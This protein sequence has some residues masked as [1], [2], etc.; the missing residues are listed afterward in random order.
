MCQS[1]IVAQQVKNPISIHED[2]GLIPGL[3][4]VLRIWLCHVLWY[5]SQTWLKSGI[6][7]SVPVCAIG[8]QLHL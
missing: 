8:Q 7:V 1:S 5:T 6:A 3:L 4:S 2:V